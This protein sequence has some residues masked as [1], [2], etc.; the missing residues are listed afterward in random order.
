MQ[1]F[2]AGAQTW[3][4]EEMFSFVLLWI[5]L[6]TWLTLGKWTT[7]EPHTQFFKGS[8]HQNMLP[9]IGG[10]GTCLFSGAT[11]SNRSLLSLFDISVGMG[12]ETRAFC[13]LGKCSAWA[14][15]PIL[16]Y[17]IHLYIIYLFRK[18]DFMELFRLASNSLCNPH[19]PWPCN[20]SAPPSNA[21]GITGLHN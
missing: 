13:M 17:G 8:C 3:C 19:R 21:A 16:S 4:H 14:V 20:H 18:Q 11:E 5:E 2:A 10:Q 6:R 1:V 12:M 9:P 15:S 7:T